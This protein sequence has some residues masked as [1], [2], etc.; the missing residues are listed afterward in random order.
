MLREAYNLLAAL[1]ER[2]VVVRT[3]LLPHIGF[4]LSHA[5]SGLQTSR[6]I[7]AMVKDSEA[8]CMAVDA[9]H[10]RS[11]VARLPGADTRYVLMKYLQ[12]LL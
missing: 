3:T 9:S 6:L 7:H 5:G 10:I 12:L 2:S 4:F 1:A 11:I 8:A